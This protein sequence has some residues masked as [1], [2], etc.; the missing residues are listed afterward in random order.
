[1]APVGAITPITASVGLRRRGARESRLIS[2]LI[3]KQSEFRRQ[4][5]LLEVAADLE[6][7]KL[8]ERLETH[9]TDSGSGG[10]GGPRIKRWVATTCLHWNKDLVS[11]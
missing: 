1:M 9:G 4:F 10:N 6:G 8:F 7:L 5:P 2:A 3:L 11:G